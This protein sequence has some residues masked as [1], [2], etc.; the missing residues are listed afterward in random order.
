[1]SRAD[2][3]LHTYYSDGTESPRRVVEMAKQAGLSAI[4]ITDHD[5]LAG[6]PEAAEAAA[7]HGIELIPGLEMSS[8]EAGHEVHML[9]FY[10]DI[11]HAPF[12]Q[13]LAEQRER[14]IRRAHKM[15]E[16][17][18]ALG[19]NVTAEDVFSSAKEQGAVGRPHVAQALLN[20][21]YVSTLKEA[22]DR[23]IGNNG[24]AFIPGSPTKT[25]DAIRSIREAGGIPVLAHP[26]YLKDDTLIERF[27]QDGLVGL[28]VY[29]SSHTPEQIQRYEA[30]A[31]KLGL[32]RTG[33]T[34]YHGSA[35]EGVAIGLV[36]VPYELVE[37]LKRWKRSRATAA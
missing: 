6:L 27:V 33:G 20:R 12:Q 13:T 11:T 35:K 23:F 29:H 21:G 19:M 14:R 5:I 15:V 8:S 1:M 34:D 36:S 10:V 3:H 16:K 32:L 9:G 22:F 25:A 2:L 26:I 18:R 4:A 31:D 7:E 24:P 30:L 37:A 28:E 17:L